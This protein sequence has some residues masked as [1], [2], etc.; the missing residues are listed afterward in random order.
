ML[1]KI[2]KKYDY[3]CPFL[4]S[5]GERIHY[6]SMEETTVIRLTLVCAVNLSGSFSK[7]H[8]YQQTSRLKAVFHNGRFVHAGVAAFEILD[9]S[10]ARP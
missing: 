10:P 4:Q 6:V 5:N 2:E 9:A 8:F 1:G 7:R 3:K